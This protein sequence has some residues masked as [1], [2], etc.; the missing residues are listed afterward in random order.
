MKYK[1]KLELLSIKNF[2]VKLSK[3]FH[4]LLMNWG[5][6]ELPESVD[7]YLPLETPDGTADN[8]VLN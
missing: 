8:H 1:K 3:H 2:F 4:S 6:Y 7:W 5:H